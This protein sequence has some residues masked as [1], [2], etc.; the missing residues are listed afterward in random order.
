[1]DDGFIYKK[2]RVSFTKPPRRLYLHTTLAS[3][4]TSD[5]CGGSHEGVRHDIIVTVRSKSMLRILRHQDL[6]STVSHGI[7]GP[8][9]FI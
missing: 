1:M 5:G 9:T 6:F 4:S 3:G 7:N 8:K 2:V